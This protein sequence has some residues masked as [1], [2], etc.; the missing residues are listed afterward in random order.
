MELDKEI[1]EKFLSNLCTDSEAEEVLAYFKEHPGE[2]EQYIPV[3]DWI[4]EDKTP[5]NVT[6]SERILQRIRESYEPVK[7][8]NV[9]RRIARYAVQLLLPV[10]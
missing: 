8:A 10:S 2:L 4:A 5:L 7:R 6:V 3:D 9:A 1:F